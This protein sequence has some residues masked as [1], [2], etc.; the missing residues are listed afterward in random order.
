M[1][2]AKVLIQVRRATP[3]DFVNILRLGEQIQMLDEDE[4]WYPRVD[5]M[6]AMQM[7]MAA[8]QHGEII[9][10]DCS[11]QIVGAIGLCVREWP[12]STERYI[13]NE[14][15]HVLPKFRKHGTANALVKAAEKFATESGLRLVVAFSGGKKAEVKDR[16][17]QMK[18]YIYCGG[19]FTKLPQGGT[20]G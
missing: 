13:G 2:D 5:P 14:F 11:R 3:H 6:K 15:F 18:G 19:I 8:K 1:N 9:V 4:V 20:N 7:I 16:L 10:A 12:W 17:M